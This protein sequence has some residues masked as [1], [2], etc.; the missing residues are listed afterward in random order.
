MVTAFQN[1]SKSFQTTRTGHLK[2][3]FAFHVLE[4]L[5][6]KTWNDNRIDNQLLRAR[7]ERLWNAKNP[8]KSLITCPLE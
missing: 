2:A 7:M 8:C 6:S 5:R 3:V 1:R 4:R